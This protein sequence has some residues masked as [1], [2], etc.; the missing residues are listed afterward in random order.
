MMRVLLQSDRYRVGVLPPEDWD[1]RQAE[2]LHY[3]FF[4]DP[5][6]A[7]L[8]VVEDVVT[9][10]IVGSWWAMNQVVLEGLIITAEARGHATGIQR[11]LYDG[12]IAMLR[13]TGAGQALTLAQ[14][15]A[16]LALARRGGFDPIPGTL[17]RLLLF[18]ETPVP[19]LAAPGAVP[20]ED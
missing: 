4:P 6:Y 12:M 17:L 8:I 3:P 2:L 16:I 5:N 20:V 9:L 14:D 1:T 10:Q 13:E 19:A 18:P 15:P 7:V 11:L